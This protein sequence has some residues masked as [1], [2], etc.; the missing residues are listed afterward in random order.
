MWLSGY[1]LVRTGNVGCGFGKL[2]LILLYYVFRHKFF[3]YHLDPVVFLTLMAG[4]ERF[5][6]LEGS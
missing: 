4:P 5:L 3:V 2:N 6:P 1:G